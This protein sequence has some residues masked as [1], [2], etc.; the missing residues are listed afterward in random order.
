[1]DKKITLIALSLIQAFSLAGYANQASAATFC[2]DRPN[3]T[4]GG[5][6]TI[7]GD[8]GADQCY[9]IG[10]GP[11]YA[12][13]GI[14]LN[15]LA[16]SKLSV[17]GYLKDSTVNDGAEVWIG[18]D[19][20]IAWDDYFADAPANASNI[21]IKSGALIRVVESGT[22]QDSQIDGGTVYVYK[23]KVD[24]GQSI[25]N[26]VN[27]GGRLFVYLEGKSQGT[28]INDGG[29]EFVQQKGTSQNTLINSGGTQQVRLEGQADNTTINDGGTQYVTTGGVATNTHVH[30][31]SQILTATETNPLGGTAQHT[32]VYLDGTQH[33]LMGSSAVDTQLFDHAE[34]Y[35]Y[36]SSS[37]E[38]VTINDNASTT[39]RDT[40][41][42]LGETQI[43]N[44]GRLN[45]IAEDQDAEAYAESV[46]LNGENTA[47]QIFANGSD[48][49]GAHI[50]ILQGN[51]N[52]IF[53]QANADTHS[54][55]NVDKLSGNLNFLFN[56]SIHTKGVVIS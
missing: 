41:Q 1:M 55:L 27:A 52:V 5:D 11:G 28:I 17:V 42:L 47:V 32:Q 23:N 50:G 18:K 14:N 39:L 29:T 43:N 9:E 20:M 36:A 48:T 7:S 45:I 6:S 37:A 25:D 21:I 54:H 35:I 26:S 34:Q 31:G 12:G 24:G 15:A 3:V 40:A 13:S 53:S 22:L 38:N 30:G 2:G 46:N 19:P 49:Q 56:S 51:G 4:W 44:Q 16:G 10:A 8:L 33:I